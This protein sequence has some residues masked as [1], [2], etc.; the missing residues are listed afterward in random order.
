MVSQEKC[1]KTMLCALGAVQL[2]FP[3]V[4]VIIEGSQAN[5]SVSTNVRYREVQTDSI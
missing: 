1:V 4:H 3:R 5:T 2:G